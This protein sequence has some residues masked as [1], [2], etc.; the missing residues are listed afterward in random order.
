M[1]QPT[2]FFS[3]VIATHDRQVLVKRAIDSILQQRFTD[4][5]LIVVDDCSTDDTLQA[6]KQYNDPRL[7]VYQ[8]A[9]NSGGPALPRNIGLDKANGLWVCFCDSDD[10][11][12]PD[13]LMVL[14]EFIR[15]ND[16]EDGIISTNAVIGKDNRGKPRLYLPEEWDRGTISFNQNWKRNH[17]VLSSMCIRNKA[18]LPFKENKKYSSIEDYLFLLENMIRGKVHYYLPCANVNYSAD[19]GDSLRL[20][21]GNGN[22]LFRH[23]LSLLGTHR[24]WLTGSAPQLLAVL[25]ADLLKLGLRKFRGGV[26]H[27]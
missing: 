21:T 14:A 18:V 6:L 25:A 27:R 17:A 15:C 10:F 4:L 3:V 20:R 16:V 13:H 11:F 12:M 7:R 8:T 26:K 5:E 22:R 23:K 24:L 2:P 9:Q 19:S 1:I